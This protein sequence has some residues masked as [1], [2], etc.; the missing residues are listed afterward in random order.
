MQ[1]LELCRKYFENAA[2][3]RLKTDY[4][5]LFPRLAAGLVGNGSECFGYD[6][7][8]SRDHDWG[9]DFFIWVTEADRDKIPELTLWK[10]E[11]L[12]N[13][14]PPEY[15]RARTNHGAEIAVMTCGDFYKSLIG[16][17][18][19]PTD[20]IR[21]LRTPEDNLAMCVNGEVF[22][23]NAGEFTAI[24]NALL[25]YYP[26][27]VR[28][29]KIAA[30]CMSIAQTGQYNHLRMAQRGDFVTVHVVLSK[31]I[32]QV[33][34]LVFLLNR[35]YKPYYKWAQRKLSELPILGGKISALLERLVLVPGYDDA[36]LQ[37]QKALI[38]SICAL[39]T[40]ELRR[41]GLSDAEDYFLA[42]H[43]ES[44]QT[45]IKDPMLRSLPAQFE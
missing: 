28:L 20:L 4:T 33:T 29:K 10:R 45:R 25:D 32:E 13:I 19:R 22:L 23:D 8:A 9:V 38:D 40:Q 11:L 36:A 44:V 31:F 35:T 16:T 14:A 34:A 39:L 26:E 12:E 2:L 18:G 41:Q 21:W 1:G 43:G 7:E 3:P 24:R 42:R 5:S 17:S 27:D 37:A 6:D 30:K 15:S